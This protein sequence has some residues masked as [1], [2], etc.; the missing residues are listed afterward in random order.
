MKDTST[1]DTKVSDVTVFFSGAQIE[2]NLKVQLPKGQHLIKVEG[3]SYKLD[4]KS[5]QVKGRGDLTILSVKHETSQPD[6]S[7]KTDR[8]I[9]INEE[10]ADIRYEIQDLKNQ[11]YVFGQEEQIIMENR[12]FKNEKGG[13]KISDLKEAAEFFRLRLNEIRKF[14]HTNN[15]LIDKLNKQIGDLNTKLNRLNPSQNKYTSELY[16]SV[17]AEKALNEEI[18]IKYYVEAAGWKP[19]YEFRVDRVSK[20]INIVY[21]ANVYQTTGEKWEDV[22]LK[23]SSSNPTLSG[24]KPGLRTWFINQPQPV[25][26]STIQAKNGT[27]SLQGKVFD[28][29]SGD[30]LPY[31]NVSIFQNGQMI[32]GTTTDMNGNFIVNPIKPGYY[33]IRVN[34]IGYGNGYNQQVS[35]AQGQ[36]QNLS[37]AL[38]PA[39]EE[40]NE[41]IVAS[42][43]NSENS[44]TTTN[45]A[46]ANYSL[47]SAVQYAPDQIYNGNSQVIQKQQI[48]TINFIANKLKKN[49][50]NL[51]YTI[52]IPYTIL[53]DGKE[54]K[55]TIKEVSAP[56]EYVYHAVPQID[57]DVFL[58]ANLL[59][60]NELNLLSGPS[61]IF[62]EGTYIG[63]SYID[64]V[65]TSD[66]M[67]IS[68]GRDKTIIV[69]RESD[70]DLS[71]KRIF[72]KNIKDYIA[73]DITVR[74]NREIPIKLIIEEQIP[75]S[76]NKAIEIDLL[77]SSGASF[78]K[79]TGIME[80]EVILEAESKEEI[81]YKYLV[82]Y[83][84]NIRV[85]YN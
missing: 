14:I 85:N 21:K 70:K 41:V 78:D 75:V 27:S 34:Y 42:D 43:Y 55:I 47:S 2:R 53:S 59:N 63:D 73:W 44:L 80:W 62:Y 13:V 18:E 6:Y 20:P 32:N 9:K 61:S 66:T 69:E 81:D 74:N 33:Q 37:I 52:D 22:K 54:N 15:K 48:Q 31:A 40:M 45:G 17:Q 23:L 30:I 58:T 4:P 68:L 24:E 8:S 60:W 29:Q 3:L 82:E 35:I 49:V 36:Q 1:V 5:L 28:Q 19:L 16:I 79:K 56:V 7:K 38:T 10:I 67:T 50:A 39:Y 77:R 11:N 46:I 64:V 25:Y 65:N 12:S 57:S 76:N 72:G 83:P 84:E 26:T 71:E 51:E